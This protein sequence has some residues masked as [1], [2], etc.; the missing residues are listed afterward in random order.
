MDQ[1]TRI[2]LTK[3][4]GSQV[5]AKAWLEK[6]VTDPRQWKIVRI[7]GVEWEVTKETISG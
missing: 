6:S 5:A 3:T 4:F 2:D 1:E 7:T